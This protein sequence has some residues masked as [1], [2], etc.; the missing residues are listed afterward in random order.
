M[1]DSA[2]TLGNC[3]E[4]GASFVSLKDSIISNNNCFYVRQPNLKPEDPP[5]ENIRRC[6]VCALPIFNKLTIH[7][8]KDADTQGNTQMYFKTDG[9]ANISL[10][11]DGYYSLR[12]NMSDHYTN[13]YTLTSADGKKGIY[14]YNGAEYDI[15]VSGNY[16]GN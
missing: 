9:S 7:V 10:T 8:K 5:E 16:C 6:L 14:F 2:G 15:H 13:E 11:G 3:Y 12:S 1:N 4:Q